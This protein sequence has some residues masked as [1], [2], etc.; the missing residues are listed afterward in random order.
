MRR[1]GGYDVS[2]WTF[3]GRSPKPAG[4]PFSQVVLDSTFYWLSENNPG[5]P[6]R[7]WHHAHIREFVMRGFWSVATAHCHDKT[8][9]FTSSFESGARQP[10][11]NNIR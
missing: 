9:Y 8:N 7:T 5:L 11:R 1:R 10:C 4:F 3:A 6:H 2:K